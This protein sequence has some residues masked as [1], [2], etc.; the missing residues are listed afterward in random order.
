MFDARRKNK[1]N[2]ILSCLMVNFLTQD[3][4]DRL[5]KNRPKFWDFL[6]YETVETLKMEKFRWNKK[7]LVV[8]IQDFLDAR[9]GRISN[10]LQGKREVKKDPYFFEM[11]ELLKIDCSHNQK[12]NSRKV[13]EK[14]IDKKIKE[15]A[16]G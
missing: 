3:I 15:L 9:A 12:R 11:L 6:K 2:A 4:F 13:L 14:M 8:A 16:R 10:I 1:Y 7:S 5:K